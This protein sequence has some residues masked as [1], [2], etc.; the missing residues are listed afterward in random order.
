MVFDGFSG[1]V[2]GFAVTFSLR[3]FDVGADLFIRGTFAE[4]TACLCSGIQAAKPRQ[5]GGGRS[6]NPEPQNPRPLKR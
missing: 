5:A 6:L 2:S 3:C 1:L 4:S